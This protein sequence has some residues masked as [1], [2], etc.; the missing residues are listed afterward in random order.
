MRVKKN[1]NRLRGSRAEHGLTLDDMA[2]YLGVTKGTYNKKELGK[3]DFT[4]MQAKKIAI[5]FDKTVD[6]LF[7]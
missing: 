3:S 5:K 4:L 7:F 6:E 1:L 2:I